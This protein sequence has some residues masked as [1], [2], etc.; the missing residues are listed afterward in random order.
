MNR[1]QLIQAIADCLQDRPYALQDARQLVSHACSCS[2]EELL[3]HPE[4]SVSGRVVRQAMRLGRKRAKDVP[5]AYLLG[6]R[7]FF[8]RRLIVDKHVLIPRPET[9]HLV[10][11]AVR[12]VSKNLSHHTLFLDIGTGSG[13]VAITLAAE[14]Q[15]HVIATDISH[16]S[17]SVARKNARSLHVDHLIEFKQGSL[18][19]PVKSAYFHGFDQVIL[20]ANLPYLTFELLEDSPKEVVEYEPILALVSDE[21][22]GLDLYREMLMEWTAKRTAFPQNTQILL[23]IDPRQ[24]LVVE[25][26]VQEILPHATISILPDLANLPRVVCL[27]N[28]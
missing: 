28:F 24:A 8:G 27:S 1:L 10:E 12:L 18:L 4:T 5:M 23:E 11:E 7:Y 21:N 26:M 17:L 19:Q 14:T 25:T 16:S 2:I 3:A 6:Y 20:L 15:Q 22:D 9:E 13:A